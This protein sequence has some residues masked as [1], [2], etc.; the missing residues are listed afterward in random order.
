MNDYQF[1]SSRYIQQ[2]SWT[3]QTRHFIINQISLPDQ[4]NILEVGCGSSAVLD[5]FT[6]SDHKTFGLDIDFQ[7]LND[8]KHYLPKSKLINGDGLSLPI[9]NDFFN[10]SFCH[11]LLLWIDDPVRILK[12]MS[13]V[14][15]KSGWICCFAEPD[16]LSRIDSPSPLQKLGQ[17]QN[18]SLSNQGVNLSTGRNVVNWLTQSGLTNIHWGIFG[19]HQK[20]ESKTINSAIEWETIRRDL[21]LLYPY[22]EILKYKEVEHDALSQGTRILFIPTFY[23]YAQK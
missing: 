18:S 3:K 8:S 1:W 20:V 14:T 2:A 22:E 5:E 4:T 21:E 23:A 17:M 6:Q 7:I 12:E 13:R 16:Y 15:K 19:S 11:F 9:K 10:L